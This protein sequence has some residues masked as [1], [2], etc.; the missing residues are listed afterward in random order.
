MITAENKQLLEQL[1]NSPYGRALEDYL[2]Q[3]LGEILDIRTSKSWEETLGR[4]F[5]AKLI[6]DLFEG[7]TE[8]PIAEKKKNQYN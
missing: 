3:N 6:E 7:M 4:Q 1:K 2:K 5:A 8:R